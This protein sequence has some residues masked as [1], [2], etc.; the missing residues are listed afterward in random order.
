MPKS[1]KQSTPDPGLPP[2]GYQRDEELR[3]REDTLQQE[4]EAKAAASEKEAINPSIFDVQRELAAQFDQ[5]HI[6]DKQDGYEYLWVQCSYPSHSPG[7]MVRK[8]QTLP[9]WEV[10]T[11]TMPEASELKAPDGSRRLGDVLLM[12]CRKDY[13]EMYQELSR[14]R[15]RKQRAG[16]SDNLKTLGN[17]R[18]VRVYDIESGE[19]PE[20]LER[21]EKRAPQ[22]LKAMQAQQ[23]MDENLRTGG[24]GTG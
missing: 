14:E 1:D 13:F 3:A 22:A 17:R 23:R 6:S 18:G 16:L 20:I 12:R 10:V 8:Y 15:R 11:G 4:G 2:A 21:M 24:R 9:G 7:L 5:L 19:A